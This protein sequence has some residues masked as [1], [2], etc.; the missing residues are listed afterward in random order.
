MAD[1]YLDL[2][3]AALMYMLQGL[4][5]GLCDGQAHGHV[6]FSRPGCVLVC[7]GTCEW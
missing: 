4:S 6:T 1:L 3:L 7:F 5:V 2:F